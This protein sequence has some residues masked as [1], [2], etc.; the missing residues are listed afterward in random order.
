MRMQPSH[1][2]YGARYQD[3]A[4]VLHGLIC[5][6]V[7]LTHCIGAVVLGYDIFVKYRGRCM[8]V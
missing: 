1:K 6:G 7:T 8:G 5:A 3:E 4:F 2:A